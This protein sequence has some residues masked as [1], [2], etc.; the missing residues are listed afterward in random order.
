[1]PQIVV[2]EL[3]DY[4][5]IDHVVIEVMHQPKVFGLRLKELF[6]RINGSTKDFY[7]GYIGDAINKAKIELLRQ[8]DALGADAVC[9]IDI[10]SNL[11]D[12]RGDVYI[13]ATAQ[14]IALKKR[15]ES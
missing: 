2:S 12:I 13:S 15:K 8:S 5:V 10:K 1:M 11:R 3:N 14:G 9:G 6:G 4:E 7:E